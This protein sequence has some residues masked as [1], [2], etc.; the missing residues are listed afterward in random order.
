MPGGQ[1]GVLST[2]PWK[3]GCWRTR[4]EHPGRQR[5]VQ[6]PWDWARPARVGADRELTPRS[7]GAAS[8]ML[9]G[10]ASCQG[11]GALALLVDQRRQGSQLPWRWSLA[12]GSSQHPSP[13]SCSEPPS[14]PW[15]SVAT[16]VVSVP[17]V[18]QWH[19][20]S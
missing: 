18:R 3:G 6:R 19:P 13:V 2:G 5:R 9:K 7:G 4:Q 12:W 11:G 16:A 15:A 20:W 14:P 1:D 8:P 17:W 10:G